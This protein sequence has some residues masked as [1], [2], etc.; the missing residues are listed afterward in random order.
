MNKERTERKNGL[1]DRKRE[2]VEAFAKKAKEHGY[3]KDA[4]MIGCA[5]A[6]CEQNPNDPCETL[7]A[8][9]DLIDVCKNDD[10]FIAEAGLLIGIE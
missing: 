3:E 9:I 7:Q 10:E 2:L 5:I 8:M 1:T 4:Y 6:L